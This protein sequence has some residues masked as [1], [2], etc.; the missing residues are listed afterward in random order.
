MDCGDFCQ[1]EAAPL[2]PQSPVAYGL[3]PSL[4]LG[5]DSPLSQPENQLTPSPDAIALS[6]LCRHYTDKMRISPPG[7]FSTDSSNEVGLGSVSDEDI[8]ESIYQSILEAIVSLQFDPNLTDLWSF[9]GCKTPLS[10]HCSNHIPETCPGAP[11]KLTR[12][13]RNI[14]SGLRRKLF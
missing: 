3:C 14:D 4:S 12:I 6:S 2:E 7:S 13:S 9:D 11:M 10:V 5:S 8:L 1:I